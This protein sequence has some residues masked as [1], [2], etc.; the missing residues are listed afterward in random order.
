[1]LRVLGISVCVA[2][3]LLNPAPTLN[4]FLMLASSHRLRSFLLGFY[5]YFPSKAPSRERASSHGWIRRI[6]VQIGSSSRVLLVISVATTAVRRLLIQPPPNLK[7]PASLK[8]TLRSHVRV[9]FDPQ[10]S[11]LCVWGET[12]AGE[13]GINSASPSCCAINLGPSRCRQMMAADA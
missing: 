6:G 10:L 2:P 7:P 9:P 8:S 4:P 13:P 3:H 11:F 5:F 12:L 1:M